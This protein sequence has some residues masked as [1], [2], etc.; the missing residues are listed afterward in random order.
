MKHH[1]SSHIHK[2]SMSNLIFNWRD[3]LIQVNHEDIVYF[4]ADGNYTIMTLTSRQEQLLTINLSKVQLVL[5]QQL[6]IKS[7]LF[8]RISKDLIIR[9]SFVFSIQTLKKRLVLVIPN[10][11]K[12]FELHVSKEALKTLK[13]NHEPK[14]I[15]ILNGIQLRD[16]QTRKIYPFVMGQNRFG[17]KSNSSECEHQ[18]DNGDNKIS[19]QHF[20][21]EVQLN[22]DA[23][24][25][26]CY[27]IDTKSAN[28]TYLNDERIDVESRLRLNFGSKIRVGKTEFVF[29]FTDTDCTEL[30]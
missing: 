13:E 9:K 17:R 25:Y 8:E 26:G 27:L 30:L 24:T 4:K 5:D 29:E 16:L 3:E 18:I 19:R 10:S 12:V 22:D 1:Q 11:E 7:A 28:G 2:N 21:I 23:S 6:G 14:L 15:P 20:T